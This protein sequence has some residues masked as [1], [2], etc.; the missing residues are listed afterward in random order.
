MHCHF[1]VLISLFTLL[2]A[3]TISSKP[4]KFSNHSDVA[5]TKLTQIARFTSDGKLLNG[6]SLLVSNPLDH[7]TF[8]EPKNGCG[9]GKFLATETLK[10]KN[11]KYATNGGFYVKSNGNCH[12]NLVIDGNL[13]QTAAKKMAHFGMTKSGKYLVGYFGEEKL[14]ELHSK[15]PILQMISGLIWLVKDGQNNVDNAKDVEDPSLQ[16]SGTFNQFIEVR[17]SRLAI[18]HNVDGELMI[19]SM[20]GDGN[21]QKGMNLHEL[22]D[23][24]I[25]LGAVN[26]VNLDG[27]GSVIFLENGVQASYASDGCS[28][29]NPDTRC[30]R[31]VATLT[32]VYDKSPE[33]EI[34]QPVIVKKTEK[35]VEEIVVYYY[36]DF[37]DTVLTKFSGSIQPC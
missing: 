33:L 36:N 17:A 20:D 37:V 15:D 14:K 28:G 10:S 27:G 23:Y 18:G 4:V 16:E 6:H 29:G 7:F 21:A 32:C 11:C 2:Y 12:G 13:K 35:V 19:L 31:A 1:F 9:K 25:G 30:E 24:M 3:T 34:T 5:I 8:L 22:A 26:A